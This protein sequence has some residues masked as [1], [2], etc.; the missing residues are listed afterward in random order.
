MTFSD[1][2]EDPTIINSNREPNVFTICNNSNSNNNN[3]N[4]DQSHQASWRWWLT[5]WLG[6]LVNFLKH[7]HFV[8]RRRRGRRKYAYIIVY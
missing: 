1:E 8:R 5:D 6:V 4:D 2:E 7:I 3:N